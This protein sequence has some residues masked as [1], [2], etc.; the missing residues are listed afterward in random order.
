MPLSSQTSAP[1]QKQIIK[2]KIYTF[3]GEGVESFGYF[4]KIQIWPLLVKFR[5]FFMAFGSEHALESGNPGDEYDQ[6]H[7]CII[8]SVCFAMHFFIMQTK[9]CFCWN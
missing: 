6:K 5:S 1:E 3:Q 7:C 9:S 2:Y 8:Y 4:A